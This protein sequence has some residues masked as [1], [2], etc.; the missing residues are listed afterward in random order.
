MIGL[1]ILLPITKMVWLGLLA[2]GCGKIESGKKALLQEDSPSH[3][4]WLRLSEALKLPSTLDQPSLYL[5]ESA[6]HQDYAALV[7]R[8][9]DR[10]NGKAYLTRCASI[11]EIRRL[12]KPLKDIDNKPISAHAYLIRYKL[13]A[14]HAGDPEGMTRSGFLTIPSAQKKHSYPLMAYAHGGDSGLSLKELGVNVGKTLARH[15]VVAPAYQG[16]PLIGIEGGEA[17]GQSIPWREDVDDLLGLHDCIASSVHTRWEAANN[18]S[19]FPQQKPL[20]SSS[21]RPAIEAV[22]AILQQSIRPYGGLIAN[23]PDSVLMGAS[24]GGLVASLAAAK[25][26]AVLAYMTQEKP[27]SFLGLL[28]Q[29]GHGTSKTSHHLSQLGKH[30]GAMPPLF[31]SLATISSPTT[32][33]VGR[34]RLILEQLVKG[35]MELTAAKN[36]PGVR[37]LGGV[38]QGYRESGDIKEASFEVMSRDLPFFAPLVLAA[39]KDWSN[40]TRGGSILMIHGG[41]DRVVPSEQQQLALNIYSNLLAEPEVQKLALCQSGVPIYAYWIDPPKGED[42]RHFFHF[43]EQ[44][45]RGGSSVNSRNILDTHTIQK[46][47]STRDFDSLPRFWGQNIQREYLGGVDKRILDY[48]GSALSLAGKASYVRQ[49]KKSALVQTLKQLS[50]AN[51]T[52][53]QELE[54]AIVQLEEVLHQANTMSLKDFDEYLKKSPLLHLAIVYNLSRGGQA[55]GGRRLNPKSQISINFHD[56]L[57]DS[58]MHPNIVEE[59]MTPDAIIQAWSTLHGASN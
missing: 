34:F 49:Q 15:V 39:L 31:R 9:A 58:M 32:V 26:G 51:A 46:S 10:F 35:N 3:V 56:E 12:T 30:Y 6:N 55:S 16:E 43:D 4:K 28:A 20:I 47:L 41:K 48:L 50:S 14:N 54:E 59:T 44:F 53:R 13:Q 1:R 25:S 19:F 5:S 29:H 23:Y 24:R 8:L 36:L 27:Q 2:I 33:T 17:V 57:F 11:E 7:L 18:P 38:F 40:P 52:F 37:K 22:L 45:F 21:Q 42:V